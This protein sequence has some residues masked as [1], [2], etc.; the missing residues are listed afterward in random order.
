M[1]FLPL[2]A[3]GFLL[4]MRHATDADHVVAVSTIVSRER[5]V[6][7]AAPIG[8]LW[9]VGHTVTVLLVG[10]AIIAFGIAIPPRVGLAME[11]AVALMLLWL[12]TLTL[13][14]VRRLDANGP[15]LTH[16]ATARRCRVLGR[17]AAPGVRPLAVGVVHGLAGSAAVALL[18]LET[19]HRPEWAIGYLFVFGVGTIAGMFLVTTAL[20]V[21][22]AAAAG[23]F[24]RFHRALGLVT[25]LASVAFGALLAYRIGIADGLFGADPS[26]IPR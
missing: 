21:P 18:V 8:M 5:S 3:F 12:G 26:W 9:G 2:L 1:N 16:E 6:R 11:F 15:G 24:E 13:T 20:A 25:G 4:G 23:R 7:A 19:I 22:I 17:S 14:G 10:G